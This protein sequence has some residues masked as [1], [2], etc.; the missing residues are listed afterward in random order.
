MSVTSKN[1]PIVIH[2]GEVTA[3][4]VL[5]VLNIVIM[6]A[7][8]T[9]GA[10]FTSVAVVAMAMW[11]GVAL[12]T[13]GWTWLIVPVIFSVVE[14]TSWGYRRRLPMSLLITAALIAALDFATTCYGVPAT[15]AGKTIPLLVGYTVPAMYNATGTPNTG[16]M[17]VGVIVAA[18][19]TVGPEKVA[20][21]AISDIIKAVRILRG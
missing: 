15:I 16:P 12:P 18:L 8:W 21:S 7:L 19:L 2:R 17:V 4:I 9:I 11:G 10:Y 20:M 5:A 3:R 1:V 13:E 6:G 14:V